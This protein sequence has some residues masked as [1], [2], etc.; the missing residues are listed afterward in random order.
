[1]QYFCPS[2]WTPL[3]E[4]R[5]ACPVCGYDIGAYSALPYAEKLRLA[6][7]HPVRE[8]RMMAIEMLGRLRSRCAV[9]ALGRLLESESDYYA[10]REVLHALARIGTSESMALVRRATHHRSMLIR[11]VAADLLARTA[12]HGGRDARG[13][14]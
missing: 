13:E 2:C 1:M 6:L 11:R 9:P 12:E 4:D 10:L 5:P 14:V 3:A 8:H 7:N